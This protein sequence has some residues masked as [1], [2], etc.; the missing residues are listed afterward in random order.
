MSDEGQLEILS[1]LEKNL[2]STVH[3]P[4]HEVGAKVLFFEHN[5]HNYPPDTF[6]SIR[7]L[8]LVPL[9]L[10]LSQCDTVAITAA[11]WRGPGIITSLISSCLRSA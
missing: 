3:F 9:L 5:H 6:F 8:L 2:Y 11:V 4:R 7:P 1:V 10:Y